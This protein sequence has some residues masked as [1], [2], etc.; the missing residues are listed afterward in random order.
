MQKSPGSARVAFAP[1][2]TSRLVRAEDYMS[3]I[4]VLCLA[5]ADTLVSLPSFFVDPSPHH[6]PPFP[7]LFFLEASTH[8]LDARQ[9]I[10]RCVR[11]LAVFRSVGR[12]DDDGLVRDD[13]FPVPAHRDVAVRHARIKN[14]LCFACD[15]G[16]AIA[17]LFL[18]LRDP[19]VGTL[20]QPL[21]V[22]GPEHGRGG[23]ECGRPVRRGGHQLEGLDFGDGD[24]VSVDGWARRAGVERDDVRERVGGDECS[25]EA[26]CVGG[27][28]GEL[29]ARA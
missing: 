8:L 6:L 14:V 5:V 29:E 12:H 25:F 9:H 23:F 10:V 19:F 7:F 24:D 20:F 21:D 3:W 13:L 27:D 18:K 26:L 1:L 16:A 17:Q 2:T 28:G 15:A 22:H 11:T 4:A